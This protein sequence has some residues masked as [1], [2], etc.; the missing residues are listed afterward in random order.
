MANGCLII[1]GLTGTPATVATLK[2]AV[3]AAGFRAS[4]PCLAGHG[5]SFADLDNSTWEEWYGTV[6][7]AYQTLR[8]EVDKIY[9][10]GI[11]LGAL[12]CL[13]L[14]LDEGWGVRAVALLATPLK[15]SFIERV[16]TPAVRYSPLRWIIRSISKDLRKS[17]G[18]PEGRRL[19]EEFSLRAIPS[20]AVYEL[21]DLQ[22]VLIG[23]MQ[24][25]SNPI[26]LLHAENDEVAPV[27]NVDMVRK[28]VSSDVV[29]SKL[30]PRSQ[31][32]I[33]MDVEKEEVARSVVDFFE[34]FS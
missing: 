7:I 9:C 25:I 6:R 4:V 17:V 14:A 33:T 10:A 20:R 23:N 18:D 21:A 30:F 31:H 32:V 1:H 15:L 29:E 19:Y 27:Y 8:K 2:D 24:R 22:K 26:L 13:K 3:M 16:A 5:G 34:R 28:L 11:S 12:L